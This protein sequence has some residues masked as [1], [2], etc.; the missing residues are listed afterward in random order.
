MAYEN[1]VREVPRLSLRHRLSVHMNWRQAGVFEFLRFEELHF[2]D[3]FTVDLT[4][5]VKWSCVFKYLRSSQDAAL[6]G[7]FYW[8]KMNKRKTPALRSWEKLR[9]PFLIKTRTQYFC[10][11]CGNQFRT[12]SYIVWVGTLTTTHY[13]LCENAS[14]C[15][16]RIYSGTEFQNFLE[17][18]RERLE[19]TITIM[20]GC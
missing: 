12:L 20:S 8:N 13:L 6:I 4:E 1:S 11:S 17:S 18:M 19:L 14:P 10:I 5:E 9:F 7:W 15:R 3:R 2:R 16:K